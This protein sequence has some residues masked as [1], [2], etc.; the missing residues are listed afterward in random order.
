MILEIDAG[1]TRIKWRMVDGA[2]NV[3]ARG[4]VPS[5]SYRNLNSNLASVLNQVT[6]IRFSSVLS[7]SVESFVLEEL[8]AD[9]DPSRCFV[10]RQQGVLSGVRFC[11]QDVR[12]LGVDR[13][14][15]MVAGRALSKGAFLV[16][17]CGSAL[18]ADYVDGR[19]QH[20][21]GYIIPGTALMRSA[22]FS[23][24]KKVAHE[25]LR[26]KS[27]SPGC[28]T[29]E[30]VEHGLQL[31]FRSAIESIVRQARGIGVE[32]MFLTGGGAQQVA[33]LSDESWDCRPDM[34]F[35]G[36]S[37]VSPF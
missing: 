16:I 9:I 33:S 21:G 35:E 15:V 8:C 7:K 12:R 37:L 28:S 6:A 5:G 23:G 25:P 24:T 3:H 22:L 29:E 2:Q 36:L 14:L 11:Y 34:V 20:V 17:D 1:N 18:T 10:A 27:E 31:V 19:G 13:C 32:T 4:D 30:C 26:L